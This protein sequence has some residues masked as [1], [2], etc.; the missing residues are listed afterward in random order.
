MKH[1]FIREDAHSYTIQHPDGSTFP[2]A[3]SGLPDAL[4]AQIKALPMADGGQVPE[5]NKAN[6]QA[7]QKGATEGGYTP[8]QAWSNLMTGIGMGPSTKG[9]QGM[10]H[11][12]F[13]HYSDGTDPEGASE[14]DVTE[15]PSDAG[16]EEV[17]GEDQEAESAPSVPEEGTIPAQGAPGVP[18]AAELGPPVAGPSPAPAI[19][20]VMGPQ[21][22][23]LGPPPPP[24]MSPMETAI[25]AQKA[26]AQA[27]ADSQIAQSQAD[28]T[29]IGVK[30]K[31]DQRAIESFEKPKADALSAMKASE[32]AY[33]SGKIDPH[34]VWTNMSV[35]GKIG[36][37]LSIIMGGL[38]GGLTG[39]GGN[40]A[41]DVLNKMQEDEIN[42]QKANLGKQQ[43]LYSMNMQRFQNAEKAELATRMNLNAAMSGEIMKNAAIAK[44]ATAQAAANGIKAQADLQKAQY[45][46]QWGVLG[47][48]HA[49][50][51]GG[52]PTDTASP[53]VRADPRAVDVDGQLYFASGPKEA[54][55]IKNH[56]AM[57]A[58]LKA[59]LSEIQQ[60]SGNEQA[61]LPG[62]QENIRAQA[63]ASRLIQGIAQSRG[64]KMGETNLKL[65]EKQV[66]NPS[67]LRG[68]F[69]SAAQNQGLAQ[70][71]HNDS[72]GKFRNLL[73]GYKGGNAQAGGFAPAR[74]GQGV[75][76]G[77]LPSPGGHGASQKAQAPQKAYQTPYTAPELP[78][79]QGAVGN[80]RGGIPFFGN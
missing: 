40:A 18:A 51:S 13:A 35:P 55:V 69:S 23:P 46:Q 50:M 31:A 47:Q 38:G 43:N 10:A 17:P 11:G 68:I 6:A 59:S 12:G 36:A 79:I 71:L 21:P 32:E 14:E 72:E 4:H 61:F 1:K 64:Q 66:G 33:A 42:S 44:G 45:A 48:Q 78:T 41:M 39:K 54:E 63:L 28:V 58:P 77:G 67:T 24:K 22:Q 53:Q 3:K 37:A 20:P 5:P 34:S 65:L 70:D 9:S 80:A 56:Q 19:A 76:P 2:V 74:A 8:S 25:E 60:L 27:Q 7:M 15:E 29:A 57:M 26:A 16:S 75:L 62:T 49:V 73:I 30:Q 52:I